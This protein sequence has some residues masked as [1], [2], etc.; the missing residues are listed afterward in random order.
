MEKSRVAIDASFLLKIFLPED[1]SD[2]AD[3]IWK[4]WIRE[5]VKIVAPSLIIF[6]VS[7]V[8]RNKVFRRVLEKDD[9]KEIIEQMR[10]LDL[11][12]LYTDELLDIAWEIGSLLKT[13]TLYD[14]FYIS[15]AKFLNISLWTADK[16]LYVLA[17]R[18]YPFIKLL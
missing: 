7:S 11:S 8:L 2:K 5:S 15:L 14:C 16:K 3:K 18:Q 1:K 13:P 6:E 4:N 12:L 9:A 17:K 10:H